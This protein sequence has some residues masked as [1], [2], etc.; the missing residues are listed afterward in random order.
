MSV[1]H[2]AL[3]KVGGESRMLGAGPKAIKRAIPLNAEQ[4]G[5]QM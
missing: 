5:I 1:F 2:R 3:E 4:T